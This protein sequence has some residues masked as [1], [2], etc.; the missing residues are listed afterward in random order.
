M[1]AECG[2]YVEVEEISVLFRL[3]PPLLHGFQ[4][5]EAYEPSPCFVG[6][7]WPNIIRGQ[8]IQQRTFV[9]DSPPGGGP[10]QG[11][12]ML[13][14]VILS[15]VAFTYHTVKGKS[16]I[17]ASIPQAKEGTSGTSI[18]QKSGISL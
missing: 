14:M 5:L 8:W 4:G 15:Y 9:A 16:Y 11:P 13:Y 17:I 18:N 2:K 3:L 6:E 1:S 7:W 12:T 10:F